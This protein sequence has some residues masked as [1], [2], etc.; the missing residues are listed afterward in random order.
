M[1]VTFPSV[2]IEVVD[3]YKSRSLLGGFYRQWSSDGK[4]SVPQ[5][6]AQMEEFVNQ[7]NE[8]AS[9]NC[10]LIV[11]GDANLCTTKWLNDNYDRKSVA[12]R[13]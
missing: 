13:M 10:N 3:N 12:Q 5:Q 6:I 4:L 8:A 11:L 2:W 9:P 7:I 1:S